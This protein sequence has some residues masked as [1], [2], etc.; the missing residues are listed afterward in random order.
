MTAAMT[1]LRA[2]P[3]A[4]AAWAVLIAIGAA[5]LG[6]VLV[7]PLIRHATWLAYAELVGRTEQQ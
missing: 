2:N 4:T 5:L 3:F 6:L 7:V 1:S